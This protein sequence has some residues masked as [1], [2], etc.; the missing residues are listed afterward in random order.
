MKTL[1]SLLFLG[2]F[3]GGVCSSQGQDQNQAWIKRLKTTPV[4]QM[5]A[6]LPEESFADWFADRVKPSETGYE[7]KECQ[8]KPAG[9]SSRDRFLCVFAYT[10]P[11]QPGWNRGIQLNFIVGVFPR[12]A[13]GATEAT[14]VP[15]RF[16]I[17]W[18]GPSNPQMKRPTYGIFRLSELG[19]PGRAPA[20][21]PNS[22]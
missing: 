14:P 18:D 4:A 13:K 19:R 16:V 20:T 21:R 12:S 1:L 15:C 10:K 5:E 6:G 7:V 9:A 3:A 17:G 2:L 11:P 22:E 8:A